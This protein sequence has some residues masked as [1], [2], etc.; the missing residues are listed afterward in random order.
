MLV[1]FPCIAILIAEIIHEVM[2]VIAS[3]AGTQ[4]GKL[5]RRQLAQIIVVAV[6]DVDEVQPVPI[7][8]HIPEGRIHEG[9]HVPLA[10]ELGILGFQ[11]FRIGK[12]GGM[13]IIF[14]QALLGKK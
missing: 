10:K 5:Q 9:L 8:S 7:T 14:F 4:H 2:I 3:Q 13:E 12:H 6:K 1:A 11:F